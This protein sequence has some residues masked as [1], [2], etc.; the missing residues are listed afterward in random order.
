MSLCPRLPNE[1]GQ[2]LDGASPDPHCLS[3]GQKTKKHS[4]HLDTDHSVTTGSETDRFN[5][6]L[7]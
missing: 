1:C 7:N 3:V 5:A 4:Y 2:A 6:N